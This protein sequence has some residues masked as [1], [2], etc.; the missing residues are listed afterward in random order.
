MALTGMVTDRTSANVARVKELRTKI[1][2]NGWA[3]LSAAEQ[4]EWNTNMK[5]AYN[6]SDLNRVGLAVAELTG[7]LL[8][9]GYAVMTLPKTN[10]DDGDLITDAQITRYIQDLNTIKNQFYG[11]TALPTTIKGLSSDNANNIEKLLLEIESNL[12]RM[13]ASYRYV[14]ELICGEVQ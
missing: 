10:W 9:Y 5:G 14:G 4:T 3:F 11:Q 6:F 13:V 8:D 2:L 12:D 1:V 7:R